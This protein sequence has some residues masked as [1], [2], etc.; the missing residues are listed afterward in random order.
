MEMQNKYLYSDRIEQYKKVNL[1]MLVGIA[2]FYAMVFAV[3]VAAHLK[4]V[5]TLGYTSTMAVIMVGFL[6]ANIL[7]YKKN[8]SDIRCRYI[9]VLGLVLIVILVSVAFDEYYLRFMGSIPLVVCILYFDQKFSMISSL[10]MTTIAVITVISKGMITHR[11]ADR[12]MFLENISASV[13]IMVLAIATCVATYVGKKFT[14]DSMGKIKEE[15]KQQ[16]DMIEN[17]IQI[18]KE[19]QEETNSAMGLMDEV[20][21]SAQVVFGA[22][23]DI[24]RSTGTTAENIQTQTIMTQNI[25]NAIEKTLQRSES[26]VRVARESST[27]NHKNAEVMG[28]IQ[29]QADVVAKKNEH[30]ANTMNELQKKT[31]DVKS[32]AQTIYDISSQTN[33]LALNASIESA[34]AG[35]AGRGFAVVAEEIRQLAE[36]TRQETERI[37]HILV[38][39]NENAKDAFDAVNESTEISETQSALIAEAVEKFDDM[40]QNVEELTANIHDIDQM[41][42]ELSDAN[43]QIVE[44]IMHLSAA[45]EEVTAASQQATELSNQNH[46][47]SREAQV[48]LQNVLQISDGLNRYVS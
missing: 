5:R 39:L 1:I 10:V 7:L 28:L 32:I 22:V 16:G 29:E 6:L 24:S 4:G 21:E 9:Q 47:Q 8:P 34:H 19:V 40:N 14:K 30:L 36:K 17:V 37:E 13:V 26:M 12:E 23:D 48:V 25:Q 43:N 42:G 38:D 41:L 20:K 45:T 46:A 27:L 3:V 35:E 31:A 11:Y 33:L 15:Q 44:N 2:V 18:A